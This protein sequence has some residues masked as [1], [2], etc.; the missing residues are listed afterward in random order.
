M[1]KLFHHVTDVLCDNGVYHPIRFTQAQSEALQKIRQ[2]FGDA[3]RC[4]TGV[5]LCFYT[6]A[7]EI[8]FSYR[9]SCCN[10]RVNGFDVY[11]NDTLRA[12]LPV[13]SGETEGVFRYEK[14]SAGETKM[15]IFLPSNMEMFLWDLQLGNCRAAEPT[16]KVTLF[17]G[18][19]LT[20]SLYI[21]N[22]SFSFVSLLS[23][24]E[25][26][27]YVNRG[28]GS[29]YYEDAWLDEK[30]LVKPDEVFIMYG[31]NDLVKHDAAGNVVYRDSEAVYCTEEDIPGLIQK[32][33][34][35]L[36]KTKK[37]YPEAKLHVI[38]CVYIAAEMDRSRSET[39]AAYNRALTALCAERGLHCIDGDLLVPHIPDCRVADKIHFNEL[40]NT[41]VAMAL[42]KFLR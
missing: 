10:G 24:M 9:M 1:K 3:A 4:A 13:D 40:G 34:S 30:D 23:N 5:S 18:D 2:A 42:S 31:P 29:L 15:E 25:S 14:Q 32:A 20:Q 33:D 38:T 11:E 19:S 28:I 35:F 27:D 8:S 36:T 41:M 16:G 17:Y 7:P 26:F 39:Q 12:S 21:E 37:I 22:P 6:D